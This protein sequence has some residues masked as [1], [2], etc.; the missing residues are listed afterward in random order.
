MSPWRLASA[1][2]GPRNLPLKFGQ[3][4]V[5]KI[6]EK[7]S[8]KIQFWMLEYNTN[9]LNRWKFLGQSYPRLVSFASCPDL[10]ENSNEINNNNKQTRTT[11][12]SQLLVTRFS[13]TFKAW[14][15]ESTTIRTTTTTKTVTVTR[16]PLGCFFLFQYLLKE[17]Y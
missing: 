4:R 17:W 1:E 3:N 8:W 2:K 15:L 13:P 10:D 16:I 5:K 6:K 12:L 9:E 7:D 11:T 14:F